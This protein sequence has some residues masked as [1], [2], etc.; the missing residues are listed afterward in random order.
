V[1]LSALTFP[2]RFPGGVIIPIVELVE[3]EAPVEFVEFAAPVEFITFVIL[4]TFVVIGGATP[5]EFVVVFWDTAR[6]ARSK[7]M[8]DKY[9]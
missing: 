7:Q 6:A 2:V 4:V 5:V 9:I 3:F 1:K 8:S